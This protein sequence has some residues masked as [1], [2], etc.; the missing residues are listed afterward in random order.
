[1]RQEQREHFER[2]ECLTQTDSFGQMVAQYLRAEAVVV[3]VASG[4]GYAA[5]ATAPLVQKVIVT[6]ISPDMLEV[7]KANC[8][9]RGLANVEFRVSPAEALDIEDGSCDGVLMRYCLH[10]CSNAP[11]A[12]AEAARVLGSGGVLLL[13]D[14]FFPE[15][16]AK[17]WSMTSLL[18]HG[19]WSPYFTYR[20]HMDMLASVGLEVECIRPR[21]I[22]QYFDDF[23]AS[24]PEGS[25][26][27]L[28]A[29]IDSM[30]DEEKRLMHFSETNRRLTFAYDGFE[31]AARKPD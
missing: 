1:M 24:A 2:E 19:A 23:Y 14:A 17:L 10:H 18:R 16:V 11:R 29:L 9:E 28:R 30:T 12:L 4:A 13:A 6:D 25:R 15:A 26:G 3:D 27:V 8:Q 20:E 21:L 5:M 22:V 7:A 31:L